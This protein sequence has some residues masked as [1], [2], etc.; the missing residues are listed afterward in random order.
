ML[1]PISV[2][3]SRQGSRCPRRQE[4]GR[5][6]PRSNPFGTGR[7]GFL[8]YAEQL[9]KGKQKRHSQRQRAPA[10]TRKFGYSFSKDFGRFRQSSKIYENGKQRAAQLLSLAPA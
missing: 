5:A 4:P 2:K 9:G 7:I 1:A 10:L 3:R 6:S 8:E